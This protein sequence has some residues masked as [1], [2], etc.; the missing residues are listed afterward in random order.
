MIKMQE[1]TGSIVFF[2]KKREE[3]S[4]IVSKSKILGELC[5]KILNKKAER[6]FHFLE[7]M[8]INE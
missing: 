8:G 4:K 2:K 5:L 6:K 1:G 3:I 7:V